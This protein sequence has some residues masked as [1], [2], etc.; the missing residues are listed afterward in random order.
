MHI[1]KW[2]PGSVLS[3]VR[4][5][6]GQAVGPTTRVFCAKEHVGR[7]EA[8]AKESSCDGSVCV[9]MASTMLV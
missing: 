8:P 2:S 5:E 9:Q 3:R 1:W 6:G 4:W 7:K